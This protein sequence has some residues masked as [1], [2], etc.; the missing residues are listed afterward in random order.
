MKCIVYNRQDGG[1]TICHPTDWAISVMGCGGLWDAFPRGYLDT[2]IERQIARGVPKD[3]ARR[4][5]RAVQFGGCT[6]AEALEIIRDRDCFMGMSHELWDRSDIPTD[7]WFRDAWKRSHNGGPIYVDFAKAKPIQ[8][9][10][11]ADAILEKNRRRAGELL[12]PIAV[13]L[14]PLRNR[15]SMAR[16][17]RELRQIWPKELSP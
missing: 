2:Q 4:Y 17:E 10:R 15:I 5:A 8:S 3:A 6:T 1:V 7:R 16:D 9:S 13:D 14:Q 12:D 11:I